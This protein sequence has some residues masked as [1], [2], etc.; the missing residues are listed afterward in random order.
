MLDLSYQVRATLVALVTTSCVLLVTVSPDLPVPAHLHQVVLLGH[1]AA[2]ALGLGAVLAIDWH[3]LLWLL[4]RIELPELL[5]V[6]AR[7]TSPVWIGLT[8]LVATGSL[9]SPDVDSPLTRLKLV[10]VMLVTV[11]GLHAGAVHD[12]LLQASADLP[13]AATAAAGP[14]VGRGRRLTA[15]LVGRDGHRA[16]QHHLNRL[17]P[18]GP[19]AATSARTRRLKRVGHDTREPAATAAARG[20]SVLAVRHAG[21][22]GVPAGQ[23]LLKRLPQLDLNP[24]PCANTSLTAVSATSAGLP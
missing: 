4:R 17:R 16:A 10:L 11:N 9:L 3:G 6:T 1:L 20:R 23:P 24:G 14:R 19:A 18:C 21:P 22:G 2:L 5:T 8:G 13:A 12:A 15:R 7:L